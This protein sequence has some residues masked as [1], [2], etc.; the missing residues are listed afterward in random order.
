[1]DRLLL[2]STIEVRSSGRPFEAFYMHVH[3]PGGGCFRGNRS[4]SSSLRG[5]VKNLSS[6]LFLPLEIVLSVYPTAMFQDHAT[7]AK[8]STVKF[9]DQY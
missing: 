7:A 1:M 6:L 4:V 2:E 5:L 9:L 8:L 3:S